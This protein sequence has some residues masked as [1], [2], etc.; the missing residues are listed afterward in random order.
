MSCVITRAVRTCLTLDGMRCFYVPDGQVHVSSEIC[1]LSCYSSNQ[2]NSLLLEIVETTTDTFV[3]ETTTD[4]FIYYLCRGRSQRFQMEFNPFI[5]VRYLIEL[6]M[7]AITFPRCAT[8]EIFSWLHLRLISL[9]G[10][11]GGA[12]SRD[13]F[14][15]WSRTV[16]ER[17]RLSCVC[18]SEVMRS[19]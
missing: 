2:L 14:Q 9:V 7:A 5:I 16:E 13:Y 15:L 1:R 17:L 19:W 8:K 6:H 11:V 3:V 18:S 10:Y 12:E 4:T